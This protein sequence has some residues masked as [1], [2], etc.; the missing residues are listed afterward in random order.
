MLYVGSG[1]P[2]RDLTLT[3]TPGVGGGE[4]KGRGAESRRH[5]PAQSRHLLARDPGH[6][7]TPPFTVDLIQSGKR[8]KH[9]RE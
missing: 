7:Q 3:E 2:D 5:G 1:D 9:Y 8:I 4:C 6:V